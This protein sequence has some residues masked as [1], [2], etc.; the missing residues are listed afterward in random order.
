MK[1]THRW[2]FLSLFAALLAL[3]F[4]GPPAHAQESGSAEPAESPIGSV[5]RWLNF[6][7]VF[8]GGGYLIAK[9]GSMWFRRRAEALATW[10][11][12]AE[13]ARESAEQELGQAEDQLTR[14]E[15][16]V[17][18][19]R[20]AA[21]RESI[22]E[23]ERLHEMTRADIEKIIRG[24]RVEV[25]AAQRAAQLELKAMAARLAVEHARTLLREQMTPSAQ[26][27][28]FRSFLGELARSVR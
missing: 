15:D 5:F 28:L 18:Q 19:L 3:A 25:E 20:A 6:G 23:T 27:S 4:A 21:R 1:P 24:A 7:L 16:E 2:L 22:A 11:R 8:G 10:I 12:E 9:R 13:G 14:L 26:A 17:A